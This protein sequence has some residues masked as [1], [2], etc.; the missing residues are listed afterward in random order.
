MGFRNLQ[1][2]NLTM[3]AN[4]GWRLLSNPQSLI[5]RIYKARYYPNGD[6]LNSKFG[7]NPSYAWHSIFQALEVI[8][9]G[10]RWRVGNGQL[11]HIWEDKWLPTP[12]TYK[13]ITPPRP[14][15]DFPM[16][17][18]LIDSETRRWKSNV[19]RIV[20]L[21]FE[22]DTILNI[23]LSYNLPEDKLIWIGNKKWEF[24]V[25]SAYYIAL[26]LVEAEDCGE[27]SSGDSR[28]PLWRKMWHLKFP[29]KI[30]IFAW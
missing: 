3:L 8:R 24:I 10:T 25:K 15:N 1:A 26:S 30:R 12:S 6:V 27:C 9:K 29:A 28:T 17:S 7:C 5:A 20:F 22:A 4:Q 21:P 11:I 23:P 16:V 2:F 13:V 19:I 18:S 14:I